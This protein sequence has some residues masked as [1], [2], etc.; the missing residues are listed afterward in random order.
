MKVSDVMSKEVLSVQPSTPL[1]EVAR[2]LIKHGISG[3]PVVDGDRLVGVISEADFVNKRAHSP[4]AYEEGR[5]THRW[6]KAWNGRCRSWKRWRCRPSR[7]R[8]RT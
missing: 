2:L 3:M 7:C 8:W 4:A 6:C 5:S 1:H